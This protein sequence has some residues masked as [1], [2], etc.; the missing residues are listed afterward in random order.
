[1]SDRRT[2]PAASSIPIVTDADGNVYIPAA[3]VS[4]LLRAMSVACR[5]LDNNPDHT[6]GDI[7]QVLQEEADA[8]DC[9]AIMQT[10]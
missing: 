9:R 8:I 10:R 7:S 6:L 5:E 4:L 2:P 3:A 1:M